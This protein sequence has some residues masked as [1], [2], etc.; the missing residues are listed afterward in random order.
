MSRQARRSAGDS[1]DIRVIDI[2]ELPD[3]DWNPQSVSATQNALG[4]HP[5]RILYL[6][7][8]ERPDS[9]YVHLVTN[10]WVALGPVHLLLSPEARA[11]QSLVHDSQQAR[12]AIAQFSDAPG[13]HRPPKLTDFEFLPSY[14]GYPINFL[15]CLDKVWQEG[16]RL[17]SERCTRFVIDVTGREKPQGLLVELQH[18]F[19]QAPAENIICLADTGR[20]DLALCAELLRLAWSERAQDSV[21]RKSNR[22]PPPLLTYNTFK[23]RFLA[24]STLSSWSGKPRSDIAGRAAV[25]AGWGPER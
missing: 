10:G 12:Q 13:K 2:E 22:T 23:W 20:S 6:W 19:D 15:W 21:N 18:L 1:P 24:R 9:L 16:F 11:T 4:A 3:C 8:F 7:A 17:L 5:E 25:Y 14:Y